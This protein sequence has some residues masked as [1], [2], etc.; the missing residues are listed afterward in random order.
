MP[1]QGE[2][3][4][5]ICIVVAWDDADPSVELPHLRRGAIAGKT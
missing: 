2:A 3:A 4:L 5:L 1:S